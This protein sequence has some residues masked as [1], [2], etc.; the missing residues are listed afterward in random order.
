VRGL[1]PTTLAGRDIELSSRSTIQDT[2]HLCSIPS[3]TDIH[4][5]LLVAPAFSNDRE[6]HVGVLACSKIL[7][8]NAVERYM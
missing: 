2:I 6:Q 4:V 7:L 5:L 3:A 1:A 8:K